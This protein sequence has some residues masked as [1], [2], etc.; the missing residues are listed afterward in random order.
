MLDSYDWPRVQ[1]L[2]SAA[3]DALRAIARRNQEEARLA[4]IRADKE[5]EEELRLTRRI[6][7][8]RPQEQP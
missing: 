8:S 7:G 2:V 6:S 5:S 3:I 1:G 4:K